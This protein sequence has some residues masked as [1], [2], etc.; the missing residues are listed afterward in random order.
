M[1]DLDALT[2]ARTHARTKDSSSRLIIFTRYP[3]PGTTKTRL[4]PALGPEGAA[5]LQRKMTEHTLASL[6]PLQEAG[7]EIEVR[8]EGGDEVAM[9]EWLGDDL[10]FTPQ[11]A[12]DLGQRM[13]RAFREAFT[14]GVHK[15]V[16]VGSDCPGLV[17]WT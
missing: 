15:T 3:T 4:I 16:I 5:E 11:G 14:A 12:G 13:E 17:T 6:S 10:L 1:N 9:T 2:H 8:Y 7:V